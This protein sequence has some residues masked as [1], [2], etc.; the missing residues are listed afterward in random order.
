[1]LSSLDFGGTGPNLHFANANGYPPGA[2]RRLL[3]TLTPRCHVQ[4]M[5][6][7]PL[8]EGSRPESIRSWAPLV[9][10][11]VQYLDERGARGWIGAG[12]SLG[13]VTTMA[14]ALHRPDAFRALVL[15]DPVFVRP[16]VLWVFLLA[17]K[18]GLAGRVH[19][20]APG[21]RRRKRTFETE[22][23]MFARYRQAAVFRGLD[24]AAL[25]D[26]VSAALRP[27]GNGAL[28]L[29]YSPEWEARIYETGPFDLYSQLHRLKPPVLAIRGAQTDAFSPAGVRALRRALPGAQVVEVPG[30]GHLVPLEKP[31][32]VGRII[33][34]FLEGL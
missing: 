6:P 8:W 11:L 22:D 13:A 31:E 28:T 17:R 2:Y 19:P 25:R 1:M 4:A 14:A 26:Y 12:H 10:D 23:A 34:A 18:L 32:E 21:A 33:T 27:D 3:A 30:A 29:A 9:D 16:P 15:I 24:D 5:L 7:R 20:L